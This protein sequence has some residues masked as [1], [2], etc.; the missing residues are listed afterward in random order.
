MNSSFDDP[1]RKLA[2]LKFKQI[3][4]NEYLSLKIEQ[5][6]FNYSM[7]RAVEKNITKNW[8]NNLFKRLYINKL[9]SIYANLDK[10]SYVNN[11]YLNELIKGD[12][13]NIEN[14]G[15]MSNYEIFP[16]RWKHLID[17]KIRKDKLLNDMKPNEMTDQIKCNKCQ[18]RRCSYY[19]MQTRSADEPMTMFITCLNCNSR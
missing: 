14:I 9:R 4:D 11:N 1:L 3:I 12:K 8:E 19:A 10:D 18:G 2:V 17:D 5:S 16:D 6:I 13:F 7:E 15:K